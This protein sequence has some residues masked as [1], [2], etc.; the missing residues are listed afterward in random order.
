MKNTNSHEMSPSTA[1]G[2]NRYLQCLKILNMLK[3]NF[4]L[5][6]L[7]NINILFQFHTNDIYVRNHLFN[8]TFNYGI[9]LCIRNERR[10]WLNCDY[11]YIFVIFF[12]LLDYIWI[13]HNLVCIQ[14]MYIINACLSVSENKTNKQYMVYYTNK[15]AEI[16]FNFEL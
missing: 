4:I 12:S 13:S 11:I 16:R 15:G 10:I 8:A 5:K 7:A 1:K 3:P 14:I 6:I 9:I 2:W